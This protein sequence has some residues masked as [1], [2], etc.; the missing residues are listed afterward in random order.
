MIKNDIIEYSQSPYTS[1]IVAIPKKN[2]KVRICLDAREINKMIINDRTSPG[3]IEEIL[4]KFHGTNTLVLGIL[5]A[6][7]GRWSCTQIVGNIWHSF[8]TEGTTSLKGYL[9]D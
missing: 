2:G 1:P 7:T 5:Y 3:E 6:D 9:S 8:S 4:K